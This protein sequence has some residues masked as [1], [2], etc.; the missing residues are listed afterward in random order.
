MKKV[1]VQ[2][3]GE[4]YR[5]VQEKIDQHG[6]VILEALEAD[7]WDAANVLIS[8]GIMKT[9]KNNYGLTEVYLKKWR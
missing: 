3:M 9:E 8:C 7:Q 2:D 4:S 1:I 6:K 5:K